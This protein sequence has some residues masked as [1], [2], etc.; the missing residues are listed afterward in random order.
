ML[1]INVTLV[2]TNATKREHQVDSVNKYGRERAIPTTPPT[3]QMRTESVCWQYTRWGS[4]PAGKAY[5]TNIRPIWVTIWDPYRAAH[6]GPIWFCKR[7]PYGSHMGDPYTAYM[8]PILVPY[9]LYMGPI[10]VHYHI[11]INQMGLIWGVYANKL[12]SC[13]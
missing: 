5:R 13:N 6:V 10:Y 3:I 7:V 2:T 11:H 8:G 4:I 9:G 1:N 12:H